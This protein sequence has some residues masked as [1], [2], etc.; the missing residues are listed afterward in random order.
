VF[1]LNGDGVISTNELSKAMKEAGEELTEDEIKELLDTVD[2]DHSGT[3]N[4]QEFLR[5]MELA[6]AE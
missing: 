6:I 3:L 2:Y 5:L 1:D 4:F